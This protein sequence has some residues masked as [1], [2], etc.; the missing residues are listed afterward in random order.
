MQIRLQKYL[1]QAGIASRR[2]AE[3]IILSGRVTVNGEKITQLGVKI[4]EAKD[5]VTLDGKIIQQQS[6]NIY[7]MLHKPK[8]YITSAKDQFNR[9]T[10]MDLLKGINQRLVP[11]GRLDYDTSGLLIL[12]N[13]GELTY[14]LTHP[15]HEVAKVYE[16]LIK[17]SPSQEEIEAFMGGLII[18][19]YKTAPAQFEILSGNKYKSKVKITI[20]EG[21]NRQVRKMCEAINHP[22]IGLK[23]IAI[24]KIS[25][26]DLK[27]AEYRHLT[28]KELEYL[29]KL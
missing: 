4:E 10:V 17:G 21:R 14:K 19:D 2:K 28:I 22:V 3:E 24:G 8:G 25:L 26:G 29:R 23:R 1:A 11:V 18:E 6:Q 5:K 9:L 13:D 20:T 7:I 16:A 27:L 12:T 15:K